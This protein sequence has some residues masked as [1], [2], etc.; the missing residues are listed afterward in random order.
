VKNPLK[1]FFMLTAKQIEATKESRGEDSPAF[2][3][4][5]IGFIP[6]EGL[7]E[8]VMTESFIIMFNMRKQPEWAE[9]TRSGCGI[10][11]AF[12]THGDRCVLYPFQVGRMMDGLMA[13]CYAKPIEIFFQASA[14]KPLTYAMLEKIK[15]HITRLGIEAKY[16]GMD[17]TAAQRTL[18]DV[19]EREIAPGIL[20]VDFGSAASDRPASNEDP[21]PSV[22]VYANRVT[23]LWYSVRE[24]GAGGMVRGLET[25]TCLEFCQRRLN[26]KDLRKI[27]VET[28]PEMKART[29]RSPDLADAA[30]VA[31]EVARV[32]MGLTLRNAKSRR[33][34]T[35]EKLA[36]KFDLDNEDRSYV[37]QS[38]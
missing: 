37:E 25:P 21:R 1:F 11:P 30:A 19:F 14:G 17:T 27:S 24:F 23:E 9:E 26:T 10:D 5:R 22:E 3:S 31:L 34:Q 18:A 20:R 12:S 29:S 6:P 36:R 7:I 28:K 33:N 16:V 32:R 38:A 15:D 8:S 35:F 13:I 2:W 4:Q